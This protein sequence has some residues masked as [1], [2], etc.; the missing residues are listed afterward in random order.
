MRL[1]GEERAYP[2]EDAM[3]KRLFI[4]ASLSLMSAVNGLVFLAVSQPIW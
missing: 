4:L 3:P 2:S 1:T